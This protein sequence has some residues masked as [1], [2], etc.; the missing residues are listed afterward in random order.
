[1][2]RLKRILATAGTVLAVAAGG[3]FASSSTAFAD[4]PC[5]LSGS[6]APTSNQFLYTVHYTIRQCNGFPVRRKLDIANGNDT[7]CVTIP[8][9]SQ[10]SGTITLPKFMYVRGK[11]A[12]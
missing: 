4:A 7:K 5:G 3:M 8:A 12:C 9:H 2:I 6:S 10:V 11:K 1:M